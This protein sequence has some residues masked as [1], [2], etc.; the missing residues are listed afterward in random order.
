MQRKTELKILTPR[1]MLGYG[2]PEEHFRRGI[3]HDLDAIVVDSGSTDP[4]P[5]L[6]GLGKPLMP[7]SAYER[8]LAPL[9]AVCAERKVPLFISSAGGAGLNSQVDTMVELI[10]KMAQARGYRFKVAVIYSD[11]PKEVI[12]KQLSAGRVQPCGPVPALRDLDVDSA[13]HT[14]AQMGSEPYIEVL[15]EH[16]DVDIVVS[17]RSYDPAPY[18]AICELHGID[19]GVYWHMG[20]IVE[21]GAMCAEPK[22]NVILA[23]VR[24]DSFDLEP[25]NPAERCT[26]ASVAAH[27]LYE[28]SRP[29]L[30]YGPGGVLDLQHSRYEPL[31]ARRVRVSGSVFRPS[32]QYSVKVEGASLVGFRTTFIGGI[33]DPILLAQL[34]AFLTSVRTR[35]ETSFPLLREGGA[36]LIFHVYGRDGVMGSAEPFRD[37]VP[38]EVGVLAEITAATQELAND[39]ASI[40]R[41]AMLH[42]PYT[43]QKSTAGNLALPLN[44]PEN[45]IGP[46][47]EFSIYHLMEVDSP[48][49]LFPFRIMDI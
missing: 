1:G 24:K 9:L 15:R 37:R 28:K 5:Y 22:G 34:D 3:Q 46:V 48:T 43:G 30:L 49:E 42:L 39:I 38:H 12:R 36:Q 14:V 6:L 10:R 2:I 25:M 45:P 7:W 8:D 20:K 35:T 31:D 29:D 32:D 40:A 4:G 21:C 13:A 17:G 27:T 16:P 18:A 23:T 44:P 26:P 11:I 19:P 33:R 41:I 47:C